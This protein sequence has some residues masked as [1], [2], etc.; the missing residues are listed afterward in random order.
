M[1]KVKNDK[2]GINSRVEGKMVIFRIKDSKVI[3]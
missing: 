1:L 2:A 3:M